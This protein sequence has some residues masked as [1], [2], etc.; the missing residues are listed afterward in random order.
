[1]CDVG[2]CNTMVHD[3]LLVMLQGVAFVCQKLVVYCLLRSVV[4]W[5][6]DMNATA[7]AGHLCWIVL[8]DHLWPYHIWPRQPVSLLAFHCSVGGFEQLCDL[9]PVVM[10]TYTERA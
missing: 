8:E 10:H 2:W 4:R 7:P 3:C 5:R 6:F 9:L 1:M